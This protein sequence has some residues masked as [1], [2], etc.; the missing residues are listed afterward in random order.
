M[1]VPCLICDNSDTVLIKKQHPG[2]VEGSFFDIYH[3]RNC[4]AN[5]IQTDKIDN[6]IYDVIYSNSKIIGYDRYL[7]YAK[8]VKLHSNPLKF[9]AAIEAPYYAVYNH[10]KSSKVDNILE[11]GCGYGY[12][13]YALNKMGFNAR[14]IDLSANA[15]NYA[16]SNFGDYYFLADF[17]KFYKSHK[18][19]Y[20]LIIATEVI[21]HLTNPVEFLSKCISLLRP[22]GKILLTTP[23]KEFATINSIWQTELPPVHTVWLS[24]RSFQ[25]MASRLNL[26]IRE[27]NFNNFYPLKENKLVRFL[28]SRKEEIQTPILLADGSLN[29]G[30][31]VQFSKLHIFMRKCMNEFTPI[32][33]LSN[34]VYNLLSKRY[35]TLGVVLSLK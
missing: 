5:F 32:R 27:I 34:F 2:Y 30:F 19:N 15:I 14:G 8:E 21:E 22:N 3:C 24:F 33:Q 7:E 23:N 4:N 13:T 9:L 11:I 35:N 1:I 10:L 12:L 31:D 20:D 28:R 29:N 18:D 25:F 16:K 6:S 17:D 26:K